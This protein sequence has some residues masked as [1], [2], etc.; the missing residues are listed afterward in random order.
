M[1]IFFL[2]YVKSAY[3]SVGYLKSFFENGEINLYLNTFRLGKF[4]LSKRVSDFIMMLK[5][6]TIIV[7]PLQHSNWLIKFILLFKKKYMV[8]F[9]ISYYDSNVFDYKKYSVD[10]RKAQ[11]IKRREIKLLKNSELS[12]F[13][14]S[15]ERKYYLSRLGLSEEMV[16]T[17][18]I[19]LY[20]PKK[21]KF[22]KLDFFTRKCKTIKMHWTGTYIPLHGLHKI[23]ETMSI[24]LNKY[25]LDFHLYIWGDSEEKSRP[26]KGLVRE[27]NLSDKITFINKWNDIEG[28]TNH[29]INNCD[30]SLGVFGDSEKSKTVLPNKVLDAISFKCPVI[31]QNSHAISEFGFDDWINTTTNQPEYMAK[32]IYNLYNADKS[33][34]FQRINEAYYIYRANFTYE[35][36][37]NNV[38]NKIISTL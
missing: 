18:I 12:I 3:R 33:E 37:E 14:N 36:F 31:T 38:K 25:N 28:W 8:D 4:S 24:L 9:Y 30:I 32:E 11:K 35:S 23:I 26:Y 21:E 16:K 15:S 29:V 1:N 17:D 27:L 19:P 20:I 13:L 10:S 2:G 5:S 6:D 22:A 34:V 7:L